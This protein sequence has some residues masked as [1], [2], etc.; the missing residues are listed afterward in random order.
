MGRLI[1]RLVG[2]IFAGVLAGLLF[3]SGHHVCDFEG[4]ADWRIDL[5]RQGRPQDLFRPRDRRLVGAGVSGSQPDPFFEKPDG[6]YINKVGKAY[7]CWDGVGLE[8]WGK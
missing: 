5:P 4:S 7:V 2:A 8:E 1:G 6:A 3:L